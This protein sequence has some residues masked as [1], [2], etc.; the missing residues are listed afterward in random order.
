LLK[1]YKYISPFKKKSE[2]RLHN[3]DKKNLL[4][5]T[6]QIDNFEMAEKNEFFYYILLFRRSESYL[7]RNFINIILN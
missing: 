3:V 1:I 5:K 6:I 7:Y 2:R 4:F